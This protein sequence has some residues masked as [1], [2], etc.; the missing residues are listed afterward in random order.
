MLA[1]PIEVIRVQPAFETAFAIRPFAV[2]HR[3]ICGVAAVALGDHVLAK[4]ALKDEAVA[5]RRA[6]RG[7]IERIAFPFIAAI[8][9]RLER[10]ARQKVLRFGAERRA[11][12]FGAINDAADFDDAHR[13]PYMH[14]RKETQRPPVQV[15]H[16]VIIGIA[17]HLAPFEPSRERLLVGKGAMTGNVSP[18]FV[19]AAKHPPQRRGG[20]RGIEPSDRAEAPGERHSPRERGRRYIDSRPHRLRGLGHDLRFSNRR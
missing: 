13:R 11:L 1:V 6:A 16:G 19:M 5:R 12:Q 7:G 4:D 15:V 9:Q 14:E 3:E 17:L 10:I 8:A 18:D 20:A 2:E